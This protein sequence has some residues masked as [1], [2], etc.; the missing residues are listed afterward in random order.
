MDQNQGINPLHPVNK[1]LIS[2]VLILAGWL[3][4][5]QT[6]RGTQ[7][8]AI[9]E[10]IKEAYVDGVFNEGNLRNIELGFSEDFKMLSLENNKVKTI[11]RADWMQRVKANQAAGKYPPAA[12]ER[13]RVDYLSVD[14]EGDVA[15]AKLR[16]YRGNKLEY[17][18]FIT[19]Y[20]FEEG[21]KLISKVYHKVPES[22]P[23]N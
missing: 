5:G 22:Q 6:G 15:V 14:V 7:Q 4:S 12:Q 9:K 16:F 11:S 1:V 2:L 3:A 20:R 18:D 17:I 23:R 19:L 21:W 8:D 10:V 13:V